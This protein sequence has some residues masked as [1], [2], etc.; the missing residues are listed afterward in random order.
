[1]EMSKI[2]SR[3]QL[4]IPQTIR[5][6]L[7]LNEGSIVGIQNLNGMVVIKKIDTD[8]V[9]QFEKSLLDLKSKKIKKL[10]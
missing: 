10:A 1:M 7:D 8:L 6:E 3:G 2:S 4:V 5:Q 9:G